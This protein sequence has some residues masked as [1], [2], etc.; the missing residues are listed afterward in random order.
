MRE[1]ETAPALDIDEAKRVGKEFHRELVIA[2]C[3]RQLIK[4]YDDLDAQI[5][6]SWRPSARYQPVR[7]R[8]SNREHLAILE[9]V[10]KGKADRAEKLMRDHLAAGLS[11]RMEM[12]H[13]VEPGSR[14]PA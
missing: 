9:C 7:S 12:I 8:K 5:E 1:V 4:I 2:S 6:L 13:S 11:V 14:G 10:R 3:N